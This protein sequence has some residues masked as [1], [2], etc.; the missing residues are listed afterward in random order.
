MA[1]NNPG[2]TNGYFGP[3]YSQIRDIFY[4]TMEEVAASWGMT[5]SVR[6]ANKEVDLYAGGE[7]RSTI[8]CRSMDVPSSIVGFKIG[9][10]VVDE[11]DTMPVDKARA[12]WR[13]I[14]ARIR[15]NFDGQNGAD[16]TT[17]PEGFRFTYEQFIKAP[18]DN[19]E[20]RGLYGIIQASTYE[21]EIH[22]PD[23]YISSLLATYPANVV[24]AY[25]GGEFVNLTSGTVY[26]MYDRKLNGSKET[27]KPGET[28]E[29]GMDFNVGKMA[30][31][32]HVRRNGNPHAVDE[33][34]GSHDTP[35]M[36]RMIKERYW[37]YEK[38]EFKR[39]RKIKIYPDATGGSRATNNADITDIQLLEAA[40]FSV[41]GP[42]ANPPVRTRVN[43]MNAMFCTATNERRY[44]I[45]AERCPTYAENL[46]QQAYD[47]RG[48]PDKRS[49]RD[50]TNDA[51]GY[52]ISHCYPLEKPVTNLN[53]RFAI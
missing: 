50:H 5:A 12:A 39:T 6:T 40:G 49:G 41:D 10:A 14:I 15:L 27:V 33:I 35:D 30:A 42:R 13:K 4:P 51:G 48:E 8:I 36:I 29:I 17:T 3:S 21:N 52:H 7:Y 45:N 28:V 19:A 31:I 44:F 25:I 20:I 9:R 32:V 24:R 47:E 23:D 16:V 22:L 37:T 43:S 11:I 46:E 26:V 38:G 1:W 53:V 2:I 18:R 34:I